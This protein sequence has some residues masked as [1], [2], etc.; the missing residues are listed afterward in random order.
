MGQSLIQ[1][2][3]CLLRGDHKEFYLATLGFLLNIR[4]NRE[5]AMNPCPDYQ[6]LT[7]PGD[8]LVCGERCM[9]KGA[10]ERLRWTLLAFS[11]FAAVHDNI[12]VIFDPVDPD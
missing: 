5:L 1:E 7:M 9:S 8:L 3:D 11:Y 12:V 4:A 6:A 10:A 2:S